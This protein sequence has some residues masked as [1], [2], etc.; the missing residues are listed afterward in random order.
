M[1]N[2]FELMMYTDLVLNIHLKYYN[3]VGHFNYYKFL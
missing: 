2:Y 3:L 1:K